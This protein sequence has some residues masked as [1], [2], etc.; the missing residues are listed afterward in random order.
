MACR[1]TSD[2]KLMLTCTID[3]N[4][5]YFQSFHEGNYWWGFQFDHD[6]DLDLRVQLCE[7]GTVGEVEEMKAKIPT[8][9]RLMMSNF[10]V[11]L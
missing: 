3:P 11:F 6:C 10:F 9:D 8:E 5:S 7:E 4:S 2:R 1:F